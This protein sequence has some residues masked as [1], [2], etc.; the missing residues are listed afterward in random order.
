M[1]LTKIN[2]SLYF[3]K[4]KIVMNLFDLPEKEFEEELNKLFKS[5]TKEQLLCDLV[6]CGLELS[7][8]DKA[9][10]IDPIY[11]DTKEEAEMLINALERAAAASHKNTDVDYK[12]VTDAIEIRK[13]F[14]VDDNEKDN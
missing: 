9:K 8:E 6:K 5:Q 4:G 10:W 7:K 14:G 11:I 3:K 13:M 2:G 1:A 12:E